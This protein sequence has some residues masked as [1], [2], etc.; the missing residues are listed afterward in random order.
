MSKRA[1]PSSEKLEKRVKP[2]PTQ[3]F[4][5]PYTLPTS[6]AIPK[7]S[8]PPLGT[9]VP[10]YLS[11]FKSMLN[12]LSL[13][14]DSLLSTSDLQ[15]LSCFLSLD[16]S[17]QSLYVRLFMR[18][19][20][21]IDINTLS[22]SEVPNIIE[23]ANVLLQT[24]FAQG[25]KPNEIF[26][27][28]ESIYEFLYSLNITQLQVLE[29]HLRKLLVETTGEDFHDLA[30]EKPVLRVLKYYTRF[31]CYVEFFEE[32]YRDLK[33]PLNKSRKSSLVVVCAELAQV[34]KG[35]V[36]DG[37]GDGIG[38]GSDLKMLVPYDFPG[39]IRLGLDGIR[40]FSR[41][42]RTF[43][44]FAC[45]SAISEF[46]NDFSNGLK[47]GF[48][49]V[50]IKTHQILTSYTDSI[51]MD[52]IY[53]FSLLLENL[54]LL[55]SSDPKTLYQISKK[56]CQI[57]LQNS[58]NSLANFLNTY[59]NLPEIN[60]KIE[61]TSNERWARV[62][63]H[64]LQHIQKLK[65]WDLSIQVLTSLLSQPNYYI[66]RGHWWE[67]L[68]IITSSHLKLQQ[69][70]QKI[71]TLALSDPYLRT[72]KRLKIESRLEK[73]QLGKK[74]Q[75][76]LKLFSYMHEFFQEIEI[77][78]EPVYLNGK[79]RY[80]HDCKA[81]NVEDYAI[82]YYKKSGWIGYHSENLILTSIFG[83]L[84]WEFL[85]FDLP[86]V[87]QTSAQKAP[88]DFR[89]NDFYIRR[90]DV[91]K[92]LISLYKTSDISLSFIE[93]YEKYRNQ[94]S[95]FVNWPALETWGL[96]FVT[97]VVEALGFGLVN[98][99][100][101]LAKDYR[102]NSSGMPDLILVRDAEVKLVEVKSHNDRLSDQQKMWIKV[103]TS[104]G[105]KTEV[106]H[107]VNFSVSK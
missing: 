49:D 40:L 55:Y 86:F 79:L 100:K 25:S 98:V 76:L 11:F 70:S 84:M 8:S 62:L 3:V 87:F 50:S 89:S 31:N 61:Y 44:F 38:I 42:N 85:Y 56:I 13:Y 107:V 99:L 102:H 24:S 63:H 77:K 106:I 7:P 96:A 75:K 53:C 41:L 43:T 103:L 72:G 19:H 4:P 35:F 90:K 59:Q 6:Q 67:R 54:S 60:W 80:L 45:E 101:V 21:W 65:D 23:S 32:L 74:K 71:L 33:E 18:K 51:K 66:K 97:Q 29:T 81:L 28:I 5:Y 82:E 14:G 10:P 52:S 2:P 16:P 92:K 22:Y 15:I 12:E 37:D 93:N 94:A 91:Y 26:S 1:G 95:L 36:R 48:F 47:L 27:D 83:V 46:A 68:A 39:F 73:I 69:E 34:L 105:I 9:A 58:S 17:S 30:V 64:S 78:A 20:K 104:S 88:L 57:Y